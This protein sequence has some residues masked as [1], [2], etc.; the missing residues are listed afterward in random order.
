MIS[1]PRSRDK[2]GEMKQLSPLR[3]TPAS[4]WFVAF[5]S[6]LIMLVVSMR[7]C[8]KCTFITL[9]KIAQHRYVLHDSSK[10]EN[11]SIYSHQ[12]PDGMSDSPQDIQ[13]AC[14]WTY[15]SS[16]PRWCWIQPMICRIRTFAAVNK[17]QNTIFHHYQIER[18]LLIS[19]LL[20]L[21][22]S[23]SL[24]R[25]TYVSLATA[26]HFTWMLSIR[27]SCLISSMHWAM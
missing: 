4:Y 2:S 8:K 9:E 5:K 22:L 25:L 13:F 20:L 14:S 18:S 23:S 24:G 16:S 12:C 1:L 3:A 7:S 10:C 6:F 19:L 17:N 27:S 21:S 11:M 26:L 15:W